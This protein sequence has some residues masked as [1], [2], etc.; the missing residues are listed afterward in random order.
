MAEHLKN[1]AFPFSEHVSINI[2]R[3]GEGRR[4][5]VCLHGFGASLESWR[6]ILP[7][8]AGDLSIYLLDLKGFGLSSKPLDQQYSPE[9]QAEIVASFVISEGITDLT[10]IGHSYGGAVALLTYFA[11][12]DKGF[13]N[14]V[15]ALVLID[16]GGYPQ[17]LPFFVQI[18]RIPIVNKLILRSVS[19]KWQARSTLAY[20]FYDRSRVTKERVDRYAR[21]LDLKGSHDALIASARQVFPEDLTSFTSRIPKIDVATL[22]IWG[23]NDP[24]IPLHHAHRFHKEITGSRL[25]IV[26]RCGHIPH[27]ER[28]LETSTLIRDQLQISP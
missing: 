9:D 27:E 11:L 5:L 3:H 12:V 19:P 24:A 21:F 10:L 1:Y 8:L 13:K 23:D 28:P 17:K 18:P 4:S 6:D 25:E 16:A 26:P 20:L 2:E 14:R 15:R 22:I 7:L